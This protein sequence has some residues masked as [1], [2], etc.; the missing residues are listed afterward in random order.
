[1]GQLDDLRFEVRSVTEGARP[2]SKREF[3]ILVWSNS[4]SL[5]P[6]G[7]QDGTEPA[8]GRLLKE[9]GQASGSEPAKVPRPP[10][11]DECGEPPPTPVPRLLGNTLLTTVR[12]V[13]RPFLAMT[14][15]VATYSRSRHGCYDVLV[16][17]L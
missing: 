15:R 2:V 8:R 9:R 7:G 16:K 3:V 13:L 1:M 12:K 5:L 14:A 17:G 6:V 11:C 10:Q 4:V